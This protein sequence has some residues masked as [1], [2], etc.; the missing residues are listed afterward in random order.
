MLD[1]FDDLDSL[2]DCTCP[3]CGG[4]DWE[5]LSQRGFLCTICGFVDDDLG[6]DEEDDDGEDDYHPADDEPVEGGN[7]YE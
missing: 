3:N 7:G 6:D 1:T 5:R 4:N 2:D